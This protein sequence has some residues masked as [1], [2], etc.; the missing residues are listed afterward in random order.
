MYE[1]L[2]PGRLR[3]GCRLVDTAAAAA[4]AAAA[5]VVFLAEF[6]GLSHDM[7]S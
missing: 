6:C 4:A 7:Y 5:A 2:A 1:Y 3:Y